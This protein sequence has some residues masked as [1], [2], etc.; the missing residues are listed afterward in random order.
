MDSDDVVCRALKALADADAVRHA[1]P[2]VEGALLDAFDRQRVRASSP[3]SAWRA[4]VA[5][6]VIVPLVI[7]VY[8]RVFD[9]VDVSP[10]PAQPYTMSMRSERSPSALEE[11]IDSRSTPETAPP[12]V[13]TR[14]KP[15]AASRRDSQPVPRHVVSANRESEEIGQ[16]VQL[17]LPRSALLLF[18]IPV[19]EPE[20]EGTVNVELLLSEDGQARTI[21]IVQ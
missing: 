7:S 19:I 4:A 6:I 16:T 13:T 14:A 17:R 18:G 20:L 5:T 11:P 10:P 21:R 15:I 3:R 9:P 1:P 2:H 8:R 12:L